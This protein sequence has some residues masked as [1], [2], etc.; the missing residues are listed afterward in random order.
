MN[1][2]Q[3]ANLAQAIKGMRENLPALMEMIVIEA[4]L[5]R[6]RFLALVEGGFTEAQALELCKGKGMPT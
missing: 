4:M 1:E 2:K 5:T 6:K 3:Q